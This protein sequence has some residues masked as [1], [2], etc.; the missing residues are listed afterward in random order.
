MFSLTAYVC[1]P[2]HVHNFFLFTL[3]RL[4]FEAFYLFPMHFLLFS[5]F[6]QCMQGSPKKV[7]ENL[8]NNALKLSF[9]VGKNWRREMFFFFRC[10]F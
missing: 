5:E 9:Q 3:L 10:T 2:N 6:M 7:R 1:A 4:P 8:K